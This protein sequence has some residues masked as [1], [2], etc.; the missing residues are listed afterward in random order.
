MGLKEEQIEECYICQVEEEAENRKTTRRPGSFRSLGRGPVTIDS[1]ADESCW[2][3][4][5]GGAYAL[6][7]TKRSLRL[8]TA[9][10]TDMTHYGEKEIVFR[11]GEGHDMLGMTFQVTDVKKALAAVWRIT[12]QNNIVQFGPPP[13]QCYI[14]NLDTK[15]KIQLHRKGGTYVMRVEFMKWV[16]DEDMVGKP[17]CIDEEQVF[18]GHVQAQETNRQ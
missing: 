6:K 16:A 7:P 17:S 1:A 14:M 9:S 15:R 12:D 10:G 4:D 8:K 3:Q 11:E 13:H 5:C 2:P 18:Q